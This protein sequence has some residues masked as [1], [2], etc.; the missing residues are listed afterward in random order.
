V[1][2]SERGSGSVLVLTCTTVLVVIGVVAMTLLRGLAERQRV[3]TAADV[4]AL[5]AARSVTA[6]PCA[7][8]AEQAARLDVELVGCRTESGTVVVIA[9]TTGPWGIELVA[10]ARAAPVQGLVSDGRRRRS[11]RAVPGGAARRAG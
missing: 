5:V 11:D 4:L 9:R 2:T 7:P 1:V 10:Q 8:V 6:T 3:A